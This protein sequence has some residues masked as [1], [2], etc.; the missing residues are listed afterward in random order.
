MLNLLMMVF[1][2]LL[3]LEAIP[4]TGC[5]PS[6]GRQLGE[7]ETEAQAVLSQEDEATPEIVMFVLDKAL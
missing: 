1:L 5:G 4:Q 7:T 3:W 6:F 2:N